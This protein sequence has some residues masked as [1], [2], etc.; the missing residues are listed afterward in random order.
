MPR[1]FRPRSDPPKSGNG[2]G[3][4]GSKKPSIF[5]RMAVNVTAATKVTPGKKKNLK[6]YG[7]KGNVVTKT[8]RDDPVIGFLKSAAKFVA[9]DTAR[10][11]RDPIGETKKDL[12]T[13]AAGAKIIAKKADAYG[14]DRQEAI[15]HPRRWAEKHPGQQSLDVSPGVLSAIVR[16]GGA[17]ILKPGRLPLKDLT[18]R[19]PEK[20]GGPLSRAARTPSNRALGDVNVPGRIPWLVERETGRVH[21][22]PVGENHARIYPPGRN[23]ADFRQGWLYNP[24]EDAAS[25][26]LGTGGQ[27]TP[28]SKAEQQ[29]LYQLLYKFLGYDSPVT[30]AMVKTKKTLNFTGNSALGARQGA[31][32]AA[33]MEAIAPKMTH[34]EFQEFLEAELLRRRKR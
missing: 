1:T 11:V 21:V 20:H 5:D 19:L 4:G 15:L 3:F 22:G 27:L 23:Q 24:T 8:G 30:D 16:A 14:K 12:G 28:F 10:V 31:H 2:G 29:G 9:E 13:W 32:R 33:R 18:E 25:I 34:K 6:H 26:T 7:G 17:S